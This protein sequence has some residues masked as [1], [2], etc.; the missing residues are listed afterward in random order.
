ML[1]DMIFFFWLLSCLIICRLLLFFHISLFLLFNFWLYGSIISYKEIFNDRIGIKSIHTLLMSSILKDT[2][3]R[4]WSDTHHSTKLIIW[5]ITINL[6][7]FD[8]PLTFCKYFINDIFKKFTVSAPWCKIFDKSD[9]FGP[10]M[11]VHD[12]LLKIILIDKMWI[13][14]MIPLLLKSGYK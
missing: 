8:I 13:S 1:L 14:L 3:F 7:D 9:A 2:Q 6:I 5:S 4:E 10:G 12:K 11:L